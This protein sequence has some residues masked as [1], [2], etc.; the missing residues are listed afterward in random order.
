ME[1]RFRLGELLGSD[2][3]CEHLDE[4]DLIALVEGRLNAGRLETLTGHSRSCVRC[5]ELL[6]D[7]ESFRQLTASG[8]TIPSELRA[9]AASNAGIR[10]R[11][12]LG[13]S[14]ARVRSWFGW[15]V[16]AIAVGLLLAVWIFPSQET[17]IPE[18]DRLPLIAPPTVR[19]HD[20]AATWREI[21]RAWNA[22]D[23]R[24]ASVLL[25][26]VVERTPED[27]SAWFYLG[28]ARLLD[29]NAVAAVDALERAD[30]LET[31]TPSEHTRWMLAA[32]LD[33]AGRRG[34][35]CTMLESVA[36]IGGG[37]AEAAQVLVVDSCSRD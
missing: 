29:G 12:G 24:A 1:L 11:L 31:D 22:G 14:Y 17:L 7:V 21:D 13:A 3:H 25:E 10:R 15:L 18:I 23:L 27:A 16:P 32:A 2:S 35:A 8:V 36:E 9:F 26:E 5:S 19:A 37:R 28:Y 4:G 33:R 20:A 30:A 6:D 34:E